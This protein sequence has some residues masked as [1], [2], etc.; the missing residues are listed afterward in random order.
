MMNIER[1]YEYKPK[2]TSI[3]LGIGF[4]GAGAAV[5]VFAAN[6]NRGLI[7]NRAIHLSADQAKI[8]WWVIC[9]ICLCFVLLAGAMIFQR[10][11]LKQR[12]KLSSSA[13]IIPK[14]RWSEGEQVIEYNRITGLSNVK[15]HGQNF[16]HVFHP[17]GK[18]SVW[19]SMMP[20]KADY[21]DLCELLTKKVDQ[22][23]NSLVESNVE[24]SAS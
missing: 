17:D 16:L 18:S 4:F 22:E 1:E 15:E 13:L 11:R 8:F 20:S 21:N 10:L 24:R 23:N 7:I 3:F 9:G 6:D 2:W 12:I 19:A 5:C 14:S